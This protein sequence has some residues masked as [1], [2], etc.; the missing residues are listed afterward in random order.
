MSSEILL[1][2]WAS[3]FVGALLILSSTPMTLADWIPHPGTLRLLLILL[4]A[5]PP[6]RPL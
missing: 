4:E 2:C 5:G 1:G 3:V 6:L